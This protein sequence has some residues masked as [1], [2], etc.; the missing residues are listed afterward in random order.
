MTIFSD[1]VYKVKSTE[2]KKAKILS[3]WWQ[4][5]VLHWHSLHYDK[6]ADR[7][8]HKS[9]AGTDNRNWKEKH[10]IILNGDTEIE[11]RVSFIL[12]ECG[13][14][15]GGKQGA[16]DI[17]VDI[18]SLSYYLSQTNILNTCSVPC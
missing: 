17:Y 12:H 3:L 14:G 9:K 10:S 8:L 6:H 16:R 4:I 7:L 11:S 1:L 15:E 18:K 13:C 5:I 2:E